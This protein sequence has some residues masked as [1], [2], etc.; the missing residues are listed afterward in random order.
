MTRPGPATGS[1]LSRAAAWL[2]LAL[3]LLAYDLILSLALPAAIIWMAWRLLALRKPLGDWRHRLG[4]V[5]APG[6]ARRPRVWLHAVSAGEM[7]AALPMLTGLRGA[8]PQAGLAV[9]THTDTGMAVARKARG[10]ADSIFYLPFDWPD[11]VAL[12]LWRI[13]PD[14][15]IVVEKELWPN[16][17]GVAKLL[18]IP[19]LLINGRVSDRMMQ[20][21][22]YARPFVQWLY[23]LPDSLCVQSEQDAERLRVLGVR[24]ARIQIAGN[25]KAD[26]LADRDVEA[27]AGLARNLGV[28]EEDLWLVAGSTHPGEEEQII[29]AFDRIRGQLPAARLL[30]AP[31]HL[32]RV[33]AVSA[34][35]A[36]R[37]F[38]VVRRSEHRADARDAVIVLDTM[39]E[40]RAAYG[41]AA[42]AFVGGTLVPIGGHNLLEP[43]AAGRPV[44][45][46][47]YTANCPDIADLVVEA[48]VG[49]RV[50]GPEELAERFV[51]LA[52]GADEQGELAARARALIARQRGAAARC[53]AAARALISAR[54]IW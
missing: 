41:L 16:L 15:L 48:G 13:R 17:L 3:Q 49:F 45:F 47:P 9:S 52:R 2:R 14:L 26:T 20:R 11:C 24:A 25:T 12:A 23:R 43:V 51:R 46:G 37:G 19:V 34:L 8:L 6:R 39:G 30:I 36:Q 21:A 27:E 40:L 5:P 1:G 28:S 31:R 32:E 4:V 10:V 29:E 38:D 53:V 54:G 44:V 18:G 35:L 33:A 50:A 42:A 7:S 22:R